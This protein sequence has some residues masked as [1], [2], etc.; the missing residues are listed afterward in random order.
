MVAVSLFVLALSLAAVGAALRADGREGLELPAMVVLSAAALGVVLAVA[1]SAIPFTVGDDAAYYAVSLRRFQ[2][3]AAWF[4]LRQ[5]PNYAQGGYPLLL[6]WVHQL[7]GGSLF[8][9]KALNLFFFLLL[10][11]VWFG[12]G[13]EMGGR[14]AGLLFAAA[15]LMATPLWAYWIFLL[16]D[17]AIV[18]LQSLFLLGMVRLV[19]R[20]GGARTWLLLA[21]STALLIPLRLPLVLLNAA[22]LVATAILT[23]TRSWV[24]KAGMLAGSGLLLLGLA[25]VGTRANL[26]ASFG[27]AGSSLDLATLRTIYQLYVDQQGGYTGARWVAMFPV[28]FIF[29]ETSGL[30]LD[31]LAAA[32]DPSMG[33]RGLAALPWIFVGVPFFAMGLWRLRS[34]APASAPAYAGE[35]AFVSVPHEEEDPEA[36]HAAPPGAWTALL[37]FLLLYAVV[38]WV[39]H[40]TTRWRMPGFTVMVALAAHGWM[41]LPPRS[42]VVLLTGWMGVLGAAFALYYMASR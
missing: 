31:A 19:S 13:R 6:S 38:A 2:G 27:V 36:P 8:A 1:N 39:V 22:V 29:G 25:Y 16:K 24:R 41:V 32:A 34:P 18:L 23:G 28:L 4:D 40:D 37:L 30:R 9:R 3:L 17:M 33:V 7:A 42:R 21:A 10:A 5:F 11:V 20:G 12:I 15:M 35:G 26:L 14:R